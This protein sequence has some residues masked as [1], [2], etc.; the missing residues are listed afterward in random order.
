MGLK[1]SS[2]RHTRWFMLALAKKITIRIPTIAVQETLT[3]DSGNKYQN[4]CSNAENSFVQVTGEQKNCTIL[5]KS[6]SISHS[7]RTECIS[8][9]LVQV[10]Y[11]SI[12]NKFTNNKKDFA[13]KV[14]KQNL[15][16][17]PFRT[18]VHT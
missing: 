12:R 5:T 16:S 2:L 9:V 18:Y 10:L 13:W 15:K 17:A 3:V 7:T 11:R 8:T 4:F 6:W 14:D 1:D